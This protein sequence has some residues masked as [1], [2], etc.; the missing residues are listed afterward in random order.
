MIQ[1]EPT[2][3]FLNIIGKNNLLYTIVRHISLLTF[4]LVIFVNINEIFLSLITDFCQHI[5][6][7]SYLNNKMLTFGIHSGY[8]G[9]DITKKIHNPH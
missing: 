6:V 7:S 5:N 1:L 8:E 2:V 3:Y 4:L 9:R